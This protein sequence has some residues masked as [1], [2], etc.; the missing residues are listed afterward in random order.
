MLRHHPQV[1]QYFQVDL[2]MYLSPTES[3]FEKLCIIWPPLDHWY[4]I[5][6]WKMPLM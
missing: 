5:H 1:K 6:M 2:R 4:F 3:T